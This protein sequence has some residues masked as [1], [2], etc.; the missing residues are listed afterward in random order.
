MRRQLS[1]E[2]QFFPEIG[3]IQNGRRV[4]E[5]FRRHGPSIV[6]HAAAHKHVPLMEDHIFEAVENNVLGTCTLLS[7]ARLS[8]VEDFTFISS[9]KAVRPISVMGVTK[10]IAELMAKSLPCA[11]ERTV[12]VRF[13]NV[14]GSNGSVVPIFEEQI[15]MGGPVTV[16]D[17]EMRR[18]FMTIVEAAQ[19][20]LQASVLGKGR[21][22]FVLDMGDPIRIIDLAENL[23]L[24]A[25]RSP[26]DIRIELTGVRPGEKLFEELSSPEEQLIST[27]HEKIRVARCGGRVPDPACHLDRLREFCETRNLPALFDEIGK[28]VHGYPR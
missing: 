28:I 20:V 16:T 9:D 12:S 26:G 17:P 13:G 22:I 15:A 1:S 5:V 24:R 18:Y 21:E 8:G 10:R 3:N 11:P 14:L 23:I 7:E 27:S 4:K 2:T 6:Y 25:G 19:L